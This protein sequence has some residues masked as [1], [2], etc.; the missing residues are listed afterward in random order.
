MSDRREIFWRTLDQTDPWNERKKAVKRKTLS[1]R[2]RSNVWVNPE[3]SIK[4]VNN[5]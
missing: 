4:L 5:K 1:Q 2:K 3:V